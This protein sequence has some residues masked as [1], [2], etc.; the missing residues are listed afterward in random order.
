MKKILYT[1]LIVIS[2]SFLFTSC[3]D[4]LVENNE[5]KLTDE[6]FWKTPDDFKSAVASIYASSIHKFTFG[7]NGWNL[8]NGRSDCYRITASNANTN[9]A[10]YMSSPTDPHPTDRYK[11]FYQGIFRANHTLAMLEKNA[12]VLSENDKNIFSAEARFLRGL[13]YFQLV[14]DYRYVVYTDQPYQILNDMLTNLTQDNNKDGSVDDKD[15]DFIW[16]KI[17]ED[18]QFASQYLPEKWDKNNL[19]RITKGAALAYLGKSY[20][21]SYQYDKAAEVFAQIIGTGDF[22]HK[23]AIGSYA[24]LDNF[25][26]LWASATCDNNAESIFEIQFG[27][28]GGSNVFAENNNNKALTTALSKVSTYVGQGWTQ[29]HHLPYFDDEQDKWPYCEFFQDKIKVY[30]KND[31]TDKY[32]SYDPRFIGSFFANWSAGGETGTIYGNR[33]YDMDD[34]RVGLRKYANYWLPSETNM[35]PKNEPLFRYADLLLM[36]AEAENELGNSAEALKYIDAIRER[37]RLPKFADHSEIIM[38]Q[39]DI[40]KEIE[41]QR[42]LEFFG[43][44]IRWYDMQRWGRNPNYEYDVKAVLMAHDAMAEFPMHAENYQ[45]GKSEIFP[46]PA[47]A[48]DANPNLI[49]NPGY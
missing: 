31:P 27:T 13:Y 18:F 43:E 12:E 14:L 19:G 24:L 17:S 25:E 15:V 38:N 2:S 37:A 30:V 49:Q 8:A 11:A 29:I 42:F 41:H 4:F 23:S 36:M 20:L 7:H 5:D 34:G 21:Y 33:P 1:I 44:G 47:S 45:K 22:V 10:I 35:S 48:I 16:G 39:S 26:D 3:K 40:R 9:H 46:I 32:A 6:S 28:G